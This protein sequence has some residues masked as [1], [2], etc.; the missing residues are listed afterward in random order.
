MESPQQFFDAFVR[1]SYD[2][3]LQAP[4][5]LLRAS[6]AIHQANVMV[7][8]VVRYECRA[9]SLSAGQFNVEVR[10]RREY[11]AIESSDFALVRD[12]D[13][14]HKHLEL[15][16]PSQPPRQLTKADQTYVEETGGYGGSAYGEEPYGG[17]NA[18][19]VVRLDNGSLRPLALILKNIIQM[20]ESKLLGIS[21]R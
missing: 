9:K 8:R 14:A 16:R 11:L 5:D 7:E 18:E 1:R 21:R 17:A 10:K 6:C 19:V 3:W 13:D 12:L 2:E 20:W 15:T 4:T